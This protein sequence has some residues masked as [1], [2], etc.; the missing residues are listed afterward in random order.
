MAAV[1]VKKIE[2]R[3]SEDPPLQ[4]G[5][6]PGPYKSQNNGQNGGRCNSRVKPSKKCNPS[7]RAGWPDARVARTA[8][9]MMRQCD[10]PIRR[11][12]REFRDT[13]FWQ[14]GASYGRRYGDRSSDRP[15]IC[16]GRRERGRGG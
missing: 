5:L 4:A 13:T 7:L 16:T 3:G 15:G 1:L 14:G 2:K 11:G 10:A 9:D 12:D 8:W 6:K